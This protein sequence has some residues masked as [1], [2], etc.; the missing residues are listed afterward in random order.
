MD[1]LNGTTA[2]V[3]TATEL[4]TALEGNVYTT[5]YLGANITMTTGINVSNRTNVIIDGTYPPGESGIVRTLT[6][7]ASSDY[8]Y[9]I[10]VLTAS[11]AYIVMQNINVYGRN[12]YGILCALDSSI[13]QNTVFEFRNVTY[14]GPQLAYH[15]WGLTRFIDCNIT[16]KYTSNSPVQELIEANR[17]EI[18]GKTTI[19]QVTN[20]GY[21][22]FNFRNT[23]AFLKILPGANVTL[24]TNSFIV[25]TGS[26]IIFTLDANSAFSITSVCGFFQNASSYASSVLIDSGAKFD[27]LQT[28][29]FSSY[30]TFY[31]SGSFTVNAGA[32]V[33]ME[34]AYASATPLL[35]FTSSSANL[36]INNPESFILNSNAPVL[37]F[38]SAANFSINGGV[39]RF[40]MSGTL[41]DSPI[42]TWKKIEE[43]NIS[44]AGNAARSLTTISSNNFT[45]EDLLHVPALILL[46][47]HQPHILCILAYPGKIYLQNAPS[48]IDFDTSRPICANP[49]LLKRNDENINVSVYDSRI[50]SSGWKLYA[51]INGYMRTDD[52]K[53]K[54]TDAL[55]LVSDSGLYT[56]SDTPAL[57]YS[58][59]DNNGNIK[60]TDIS[61]DNDKGILLRLGN[62]PLFNGET[63]SAKIVW[64]LEVPDESELMKI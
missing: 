46:Q 14:T 50:K 3:Y 11:S 7:A 44:L 53:H 16:I 29:K 12:Y 64:T 42:Y 20:S 62:E 52:G 13:T 30:S 4:K 49:V 24:N 31:C 60:T 58:G 55:V 9:C 32:L 1:I 57:V 34:A 51:A 23:G 6:D 8:N 27:M 39:L 43:A 47:L 19:N 28:T 26:P 35:A 17:V 5:V 59:T 21:A 25:T 45:L 63:Y 56:L 54:L 15:A 10:N 38:S 18:G 22:T 48:T 36:V 61:W 40:W 33:Y 37:S 41:K 2:V